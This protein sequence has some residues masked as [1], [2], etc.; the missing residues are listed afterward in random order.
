M[1]VVTMMMVMVVAAV[2]AA[3]AAAMVVV[4]V[5]VREDSSLCLRAFAGSLPSGRKRRKL[6]LDGKVKREEGNPPPGPRRGKHRPR[7]L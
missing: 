3:A 4:L 2:V 1:V 5:G 6:H 7:H